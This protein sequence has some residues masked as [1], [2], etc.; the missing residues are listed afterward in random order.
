MRSPGS[1]SALRQQ[2]VEASRRPRCRS[3]LQDLSS[4]FYAIARAKLGKQSG[5]RGPHTSDEDALAAIRI[6]RITPGSAV[7]EADPPIVGFQPR[8]EFPDETTAEDV[9]FDFALEAQRLDRKSL[10]FFPPRSPATCASGLERCR[11]DW[12]YDGIVLRPKGTKPPVELQDDELRVR[13]SA[14]EMRGIPEVVAPRSSRPRRWS[15]HAY[16]VDVEP[17]RW[18][19]RLKL[20]DGRDLTLEAASSSHELP[21]AGS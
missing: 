12:A 9:L 13:V 18:R 10:C 19:M 16:M 14:E 3:S 11:R 8:L 15:G 5:R 6:V 17:G 21:E 1:N 2:R 4:A 7:I 20:P